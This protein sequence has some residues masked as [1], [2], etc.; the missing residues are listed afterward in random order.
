MATTTTFTTLQQDIRRYLERGFTLAS[1]AIVYEQI[2]R[3]INLAE[4]RIAR[5][6]KVE[7]LINVVTSTMQVGLAVYPKPDRWRTTVSFNYGID[8]QY[9]QLFP[10]S[11][12]YVRS[13]WPNRDE[14]SPPLFYADYDY[15]N[16][17]VSPTPDQAYPFEVLVYQLLPLLDD[18][19]QTN[20]LTE[21]AP[22]VLL[23]ASLLE[24]TP[25]LKNDERIAVW[26]SMYDRSAQALNGED[27]S[28]ILDRSARRTEA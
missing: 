5:E 15:N 27:L 26:Q 24:A 8:N 28:K 2:P 18:S 7:G 21:Y 4:R 6:L 19:N 11:Y 9:T 22:Q 1:D 3:L 17:I 13:Y 23:Y 12:E 20:W 25:F 14:T 16:W 10:R